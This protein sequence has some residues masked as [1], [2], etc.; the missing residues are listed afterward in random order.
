MCVAKAA[1]A[2]VE[3]DRGV[4][5]EKMIVTRWPWKSQHPTL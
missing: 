4:M 3:E 5:S 2:A 1:W